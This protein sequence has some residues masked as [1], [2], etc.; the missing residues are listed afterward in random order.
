MQGAEAA[1]EDTRWSFVDMAE[2]YKA[3]PRS[4]EIE[5]AGDAARRLRVLED[6]QASIRKRAMAVRAE[7]VLD[8]SDRT[9]LGAPAVLLAD[10]ALML[11]ATGTVRV[12]AVDMEGLHNDHPKTIEHRRR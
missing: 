3:D 7:L 5:A 1:A 8:L 6:I 2:L 11:P 4:A 9:P 12:L 10:A